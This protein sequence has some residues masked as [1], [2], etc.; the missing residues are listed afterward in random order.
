[1]NVE[2]KRYPE[3]AQESGKDR[4]KTDVLI[5]SQQGEQ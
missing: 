5:G 3:K 4:L 2:V 1:M